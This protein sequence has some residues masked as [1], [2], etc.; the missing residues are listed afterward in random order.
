MNI[1]P[2]RAAIMVLTFSTQVAE[3]TSKA[4]VLPARDLTKSCIAN[5]LQNKGE[6]KLYEKKNSPLFLAL[7][8]LKMTSS[9]NIFVA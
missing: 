1:L 7:T 3:E 6:R 5:K 9:P 8:G 2:S 4:R